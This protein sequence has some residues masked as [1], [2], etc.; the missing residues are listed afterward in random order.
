[1]L[2]KGFCWSRS[3]CNNVSDCTDRKGELEHFHVKFHA[4]LIV[5]EK[6]SLKTIKPNNDNDSSADDDKHDEISAEADI[7]NR[8]I[9]ARVVTD[10]APVPN[11]HV[12]EW[13]KRSN[14]AEAAKIDFERVLAN[15]IEH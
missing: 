10:K 14:D 7:E 1:M 2:G 9:F 11:K 12:S 15:C 5:R 8:F 3:I 13:R 6:K 4:Q